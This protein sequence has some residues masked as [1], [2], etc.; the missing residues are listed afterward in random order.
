[1]KGL[2]TGGFMSFWKKFFLV[3]AFLIAPFFVS[4]FIVIPIAL[5]TVLFLYRAQYMVKPLP[6]IENSPGN[7]GIA[8][9]HKKYTQEECLMY[10]GRE[11]IIKKGYQPLQLSIANQTS[12]SYI[13]SASSLSLPTV[14]EEC[15]TNEFK[16]ASL[17]RFFIAYP[18]IGI[19]AG[20]LGCIIA[21]SMI[22][23]HP[24]FNPKFAWLMSV[25][26]MLLVCAL[27][28]STARTIYMA[29]SYSIHKKLEI[30]YKTKSFPK[31][32][33]IRPGQSINGIVFVPNESFCDSF[34]V[35]INNM[36]SNEAVVLHANTEDVTVK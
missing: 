16:T 20:L 11:K 24:L 17:I 21:V 15:V 25:K 19:F 36:Q 34:T 30:D 31:E 12:N 23:L 14:S 3:M 13:F 1:M 18:I 22:F 29:R 4:I 32:T 33:I 9:M 10:L 28:I 6:K 8:M 27:I 26:I 35:T 2:I 5:L 7:T